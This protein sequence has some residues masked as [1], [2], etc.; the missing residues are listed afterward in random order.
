[1]CCARVCRC[2]AACCAQGGAG[3]AHRPDRRRRARR[4]FPRSAKAAYSYVSER[5]RAATAP[6][7]DPR[8]PAYF[9]VDEHW[10]VE[11]RTPVQL[12]AVAACVPVRPAVHGR[13]VAKGIW[14]R[15]EPGSRSGGAGGPPQSVRTRRVVRSPRLRR[16]GSD[17][18]PLASTGRVPRVRSGVASHVASAARRVVPCPYFRFLILSHVLSVRAC[19]VGPVT[20]A[21]RIRV[22]VPTERSHRRGK[23]KPLR[24]AGF[25][26]VRGFALHPRS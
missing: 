15:F 7:G 13:P 26:I 8:E 24:P 16:P 1:M 6:G 3:K 21:S 4:D 18:T 14:N 12:S 19:G 5:S 25:R 10:S 23:S 17:R 22:A 20:R 2:R 9:V 11:H